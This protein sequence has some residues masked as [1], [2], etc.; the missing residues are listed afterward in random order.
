M[1]RIKAIKFACLL[2]MLSFLQAGQALAGKNDLTQISAEFLTA[3]DQAEQILRQSNSF[4]ADLYLAL[5]LGTIRQDHDQSKSEI[6]AIFNNLAGRLDQKE[7]QTPIVNMVAR[8]APYEGDIADLVLWL[9]HFAVGQLHQVSLMQ[10]PMQISCDLILRY[11]ALISLTDPAYGS[12]QDHIFPQS[13]C[14]T[15]Q[16]DLPVSYQH[17]R[18][19]IGRSENSHQGSIRFATERL[20]QKQLIYVSAF[21]EKMKPVPVHRACEYPL[22]RWALVS[23]GHWFAFLRSRE[24]YDQAYR[25]LRRYYRVKLQISDEKAEN[26][27]ASALWQDHL[28]TTE[29]VR[30]CAFHTLRYAMASGEALENVM[31]KLTEGLYMIGDWAA[32]YPNVSAA[33]LSHFAVFNPSLLSYL[34]KKED[35]VLEANQIGKT[36]LMVAAQYDQAEAIMRLLHHGADIHAVTTERDHT[37]EVTG[38]TALMYAA[39]YGSQ[40]TVNLL[41]RFGAAP[42]ARDSSGKMAKDYALLNNQPIEIKDPETISPEFDCRLPESDINLAFC[43][44]DETV[45]IS[46]Q[47]TDLWVKVYEKL[48]QSER[49][50][51]AR[52]HREWQQQHLGSCLPLK[53]DNDVSSLLAAAPCLIKRSQRR[54]VEMAAEGEAG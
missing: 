26:Y 12:S 46:R 6:Q 53:S 11:P 43:L 30:S 33:P 35:L 3:P 23:P 52:E 54:M 29:E 47:L 45:N 32:R 8:P 10:A 51:F 38:R 21:P 1:I 17:Y 14:Q 40:K 5:F 50:R 37:G 4:E 49:H 15:L 48:S 36:P 34:V 2:S 22:Q 25:D 18:N 31:P 9:R 20:R 28:A 16:E 7:A 27:A 13:D 42:L 39:Q 41:I 24:L 19:F 44:Q